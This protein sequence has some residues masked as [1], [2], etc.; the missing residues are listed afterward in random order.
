MSCR[1]IVCCAMLAAAGVLLTAGRSAAESPAVAL[2][3]ETMRDRFGPN[4]Y[5]YSPGWYGPG[6][7]LTNPGYYGPGYESELWYWSNVSWPSRSWYMTYGAGPGGYRVFYPRG[8]GDSYYYS[9]RTGVQPWVKVEPLLAEDRTDWQF[10]RDATPTRHTREPGEEMTAATSGRL[11]D[12]AT[13][14]VEVHPPVA[15]ATI[16]IEGRKATQKGEKLQFLSPPLAAGVDY[17]Y[18]IRAQWTEGGK[19]READR[20]VSVRAGATVVVDFRAK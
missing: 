5:I 15:D 1:G 13:V 7:V 10:P 19:E 8:K 18:S 12:P 2:S 14:L 11:Q 17:V 6:G 20:R 3:D 9:H 16:W 4:S